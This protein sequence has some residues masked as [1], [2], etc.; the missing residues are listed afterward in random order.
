MVR[1][2]LRYAICIELTIL[3]VK[4]YPARSGNGKQ[5][6]MDYT[7]T[8]PPRVPVTKTMLDTYAIM[9]G[10]RDKA[11]HEYGPLHS[12]LYNYEDRN[13]EKGDELTDLPSWPR[14]LDE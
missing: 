8:L 4:S 3:S 12:R 9:R 14:P 11:L 2:T 10:N 1:S 7:V 13:G 6:E 5:I